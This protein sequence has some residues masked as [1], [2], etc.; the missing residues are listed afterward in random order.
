MAA[1]DCPAKKIVVIGPSWVGDMVMA[2]AL[3]AVLKIENPHCVIDV[4]APSATYP[5]L[6]RMSEVR[7]G[8]L[9][10]ADHGQ[11]AVTERYR[12]GLELRNEAY[13]Q[14][15]VLPNSFKSALTPV[16]AH[17]PQRTGW[18]GEC[19]YG[20]LNDL[21]ILNHSDLPLMVDRFVSLAYSAGVELPRPLCRPHLMADKDTLENSLKRHDLQLARPILG[22]CPGAEFGLAK[23][24]PADH[25]ALVAEHYLAKGWQVWVFGSN[26]DLATAQRLRDQVSG[27][28]RRFCFNLAGK[29]SLTEAIDLIAQVAVVL[30]ND[31]G[32]MHIAAALDRQLFV[33]Y[34]SSSPQF[35]PPLSDQATVISLDLPCSPCFQ[36]TCPLD[37]TDCLQK[38]SAGQVLEEMK[39]IG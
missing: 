6:A 15:Y 16:F 19:R 2:Q 29:T 21:R 37:H 11:L 7:R 17:I 8:W 39:S 38:L 23:Q 31:S 3:F 4:V 20:V 26:K 13:D 10:D 32:L 25:Y 9:L 1:D 27:Q 18:R 5:L 22:L 28:L 14:A 34:G 12:M 35:T 36:R 30:T 33:L 24:W